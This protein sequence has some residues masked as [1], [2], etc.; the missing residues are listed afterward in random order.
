MKDGVEYGV[1]LF[2]WQWIGS[3]GSDRCKANRGWVSAESGVRRWTNSPFIASDS[4]GIVRCFEGVEGP[5][6]SL[7]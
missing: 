1:G 5:L 2:W 3:V 4:V 6:S 7:R